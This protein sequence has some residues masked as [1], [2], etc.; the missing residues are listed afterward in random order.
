MP[1]PARVRR[2]SALRGFT[3][4]ELLVVI[5][6]IGVLIA[7][8]LP[9]I[10]AAREAAR[11]GACVNKQ[12]QIALA[13]N[14]YVS[15]FKRFPPGDAH[16]EAPE[17]GWKNG[18]NPT[19]TKDCR[20]VGWAV[21]ILDQLEEPGFAASVKT[22]LTKYSHG[23]DDLDGKT[24]GGVKQPNVSGTQLDQFLCPSAPQ[25]QNVPYGSYSFEEIGKGNYV[26]NFGKGELE[27]VVKSMS[28][29]DPTKAGMFDVVSISRPGIQASGNEANP[30]QWKY[31]RSQGVRPAEVRDGLS[32]TV[33]V[34]EIRNYDSTRDIRGA[35]SLA[36]M[37]GSSFTAKNGI[38]PPVKD[39]ANNNLYDV[40]GGCDPDD[41]PAETDPRYCTR[42][43]TDGKV[44]ASVRSEHSGGVVAAMGDGSA[45]FFPDS[46]DIKVWHQLAT[47]AGK[48]I[49]EG[50]PVPE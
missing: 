49:D 5:A 10:Q 3:L 46:T 35:W 14:N 13:L 16:C 32:K 38:N 36:S 7:L 24:I 1:K 21:Q 30:G 11:R 42:N 45:R 25:L 20:G 15:S 34:S 17:E 18:G 37:G 48:P 47:R 29:W 40:I 44:W 28:T 22:V 8:L 4:V 43:R 39:N 26:G 33:L 50:L 2:R 6:I 19:Y 31:A 23:A 12:K 9:A 41:R 27:H